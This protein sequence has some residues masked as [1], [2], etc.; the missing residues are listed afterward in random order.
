MNARVYELHPLSEEE[1]WKLFC[2]FAFEG[3][4]P[5]HHLEGIAHQ[6]E[7]ECGR[8]PLAVKT[9]AASL[10]NETLS[11][12]AKE[13]QCA[14]SVEESFKKGPVV[15]TSSRCRRIL[16]GKKSIGDGDL[17][18]MA[19]SQAYSAS[20]IRTLSFPQNKGIGNIP[21]LLLSG[22]R[23]L[24]VLDLI[25]TAISS[26]PD[27]VGN[28]KLLTVL[29][30]SRNQIA[31]VPECLKSIKSLLFLDISKC[32]NLEGYP[33]WIGELNCLKNLDMILYTTKFDGQMPKGMSKLVSL[34]VL[35][36][37]SC[38]ELSVD[39]NEFLRLEHFVNL[40]NLREVRID[41]RHETE[42]ESIKDG[43]LAR[44]VKMRNLTMVNDAS[45]EGNLL[46][47]MLGMKDLEY[48]Y[49]ERVRKARG[50]RQLCYF[51]I[52]DFSVLEEFPEL[53][54]GA[55]PHLELLEVARY[56]NL[57]K[58]PRGLE[59]LKCLKRCGFKW[60]GVDDMLEEGGELWEKIKA[61]NSN[62]IINTGY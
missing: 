56:S 9:V 44:L 49:L 14:F 43:I 16:M 34:E 19:S 32:S 53:E 54:D 22:A 10:A 30:L 37:D 51:K 4:Q 39:K 59:L 5:P 48:L 11:S 26:L 40:V 33:V 18:V 46:E 31:E 25:D 15:Q 28:L 35:K 57:N 60:T 20:R 17:D 58:I 42:L 61:N 62:V 1:S 23:L 27:C 12:I 13:I 52:R 45:Y 47:E 2:A 8:L 24:R 29:N 21:A 41:I 6:I 7:R 50:I 38:N 36:I 55:M 3:N